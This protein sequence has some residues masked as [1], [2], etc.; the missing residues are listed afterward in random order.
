MVALV[1]VYQQGS[2]ARSRRRFGAGIARCQDILPVLAQLP[3]PAPA[4]ALLAPGQLAME[5]AVCRLGALLVGAGARSVG[6]AHV[7]ELLLELA[8]LHDRVVLGQ[9]LGAVFPI[10]GLIDKPE[11]ADTIPDA[12]M[13]VRIDDP[14]CASIRTY[15]LLRNEDAGGDRPH[16][17]PNAIKNPPA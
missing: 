10:F 5:H 4:P 6:P 12:P 13:H 14:V 1:R 15:Q 17:G 16:I 3:Q 9:V 2:S 8:L 11:P 7:D